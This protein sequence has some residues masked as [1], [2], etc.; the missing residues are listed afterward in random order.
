VKVKFNPV[1]GVLKDRRI[2]V[3]EDSI[4]RG[5]TLRI[6]TQLLRKAGAK[7]VHVRVSSPPIRYP[8][9]FG[10]DFPTKEELVAN[11][12]SI[13]EIKAHLDVESLGYLSMEGLVSAVSSKGAGYCT[14]CFGGGYP[15]PIEETFEKDQ[16]DCDSAIQE[17]DENMV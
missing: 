7:E 1:G 6:L 2:V 5:T 15:I 3:V 17:V 13:D 8:C 16:Y 14:A 10:M 11:S 12:K 9:Y 4:V